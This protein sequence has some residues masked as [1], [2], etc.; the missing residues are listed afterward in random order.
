MEK[1]RT[2]LRELDKKSYGAYKSIKGQHPLGEFTLSIDHVQGDPFAAP[3]HV[4]LQIP[5][6]KTGF[7]QDLWRNSSRKTAFEDFIAREI[8]KNCKNLLKNQ[9]RGSG[10]SGDIAI[11]CNQQQILQRNAVNLVNNALDIRMTLGLP[12]NGRRIAGYQAEEMIYDDL[13]NVLA[14]SVFASALD[15]DVLQHHVESCE[16][17]EFLRAWLGENDFIAFVANGSVLPRR[18]GVD[19]RPLSDNPIK[20]QSPES[21]EVAVDLPNQGKISGMAIPKGITLIVG[22]GFHGKST[23]LNALE[24]GVY[25]HIPNDGRERVVTIP[26]AVK[27][28]AEDGRRV[29]DVDISCFIDHLPFAKDTRHF[30]TENASGSTSQ[31]ANIVEAITSGAETLLIDEDTSASNFMIRDARMQALVADEKEPITPLIYR[32]KDIFEKHGISTIIVMGGS[33]DYFSVADR[34]IMLDAYRVLDVTEKAHQIAQSNALIA[35]DKAPQSYIQESPRAPGKRIL[36]G[37]RGKNPFKFDVRDVHQ[38]RY[39]EHDIDLSAVEQ[40]ID[41]GQTRCIAWFIHYFSQHFAAN[42]QDVVHM[43]EEI[44]KLVEQNGLD[45]LTDFKIGSLALPRK[46]EVLAAIN[47]IREGEWIAPKI[48]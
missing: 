46:F 39:G 5:I 38:L 6:E 23:L 24:L 3:S 20:F 11:S 37:Q 4:S 25:N 18:S 26:S 27:I 19:D 9:R 13:P 7:S 8:Q 10:K 48:T 42:Q 43:V 22:G 1:L 28:R 35:A 30:N 15:I 29:S 33:G 36:S 32:I 41:A 34:V 2:K 31:A 17:Q 44:Y 47:R 45:L 21:L 16:D 40:L 12:A 14:H